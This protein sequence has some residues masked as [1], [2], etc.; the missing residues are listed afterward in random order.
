MTVDA[1]NGDPAVLREVVA[2]GI[3]VLRLNRP[4]QRN[5]MN[6]ES[7]VVLQSYVHELARADDVRAVV[8]TGEGEVFCSG[9]DIKVPPA[10]GNR[11][12][13][14][15][16][17]LG[18][19]HQVLLALR[20]AP[21]PV[22]AAVEGAAIGLGWSLA[23]ACD[24]V[25]A[26]ADVR[27]VAPF[28]DR[29]LVPDGG[30]AWELT[31][32]LGRFAASELLLEGGPMTAGRAAEVGLVNKLCEPGTALAV[33]TALARV[34]A[35]RDPRAVELTKA[36]VDRAQSLPLAGYLDLELPYAALTQLA[37]STPPA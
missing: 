16:A 25:V 19:A 3:V 4:R 30:M 15:A 27:F 37:N 5:A 24:L 33:A 9:G 2:P 13:A 26:A 23:L 20:H 21:V 28:L 36:M 35:E 29:G 17:R 11:A 12:L 10:R 31:N 22:I 6:W 34:I 7:W 18:L 14:P 1:A 32:R 8:L